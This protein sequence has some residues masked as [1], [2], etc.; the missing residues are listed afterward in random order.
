MSETDE[1]ADA[2]PAVEL[3]EGPA[4]EG[5]PVARVAARL[6]WP[7]TRSEVQTQEG[8]AVVRTPDGPAQLTEVLEESD[9]PLYESRSEFRAAVTDVVGDGPVATE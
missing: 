5:E 1:D 3:G 6:T 9:V 4:V 2:E 7:A 8:N